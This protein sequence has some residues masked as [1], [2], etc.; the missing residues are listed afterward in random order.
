MPR[1]S[2]VCSRKR[3]QSHVAILAFSLAFLPCILQTASAD[4]GIL[5]VLVQ[6]ANKHPIKGI[7]IGIEG[8]GGSH[9]T[10][11]DGKALLQLS[12]HTSENDWVSLQ[13]IHSPP[14]KD[15]VIVSPYDDRTLVPSFKN[16]PENFVLVTVIEHGDY[17]ALQNRTVLANLTAK[18]DKIAERGG[19]GDQGQ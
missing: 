19:S 3:I 8:G 4:V 5:Q 6:D 9:T 16:K 10:G 7:E 13:I 17:T 12:K 18:I 14:G 2:Q 15:F 11:D 1:R